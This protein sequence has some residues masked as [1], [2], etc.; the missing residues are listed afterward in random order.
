M[1]ALQYSN[2]LPADVVPVV[3]GLLIALD[4]AMPGAVTGFYL[5]GSLALDDYWPGQ[6]DVDFIAVIDRNTDVSPLASV[7]CDLAKV[8]PLVSCDGLY[9]RSG[10]LGLAPG[11]VGTA[12][13]DGV[14]THDS[15]DERHAVTWLTLLRHG[16]VMRGRAPSSDWIAG[17]ID[18][19]IQYSREN[20][21]TYW[22]PWLDR[23][24][25]EMGDRSGMLVSD[26]SVIWGCLGILRLHAAIVTG[27]MVSKTGA[28]RHGLRHFPAHR[29]IIAEVMG[30]RSGAT[31]GYDGT[32]RRA[33][34]LIGLMDAV[35]QDVP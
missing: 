24:K 10:E 23:L 27:E 9:L 22:L 31:R 7:H 20:L 2:G 35:L 12:A 32:I 30:L 4:Q 28:G 19:A 15:P 5:L 14:V 34:A 18:A 21:R 8:W 26:G 1:S 33:D 29:G 13:R 6:S 3:N 16:R 11:G 17:D 25:A